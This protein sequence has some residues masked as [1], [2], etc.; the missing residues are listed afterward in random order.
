M[1]YDDDDDDDDDDDGGDFIVIF[2]D[3]KNW[4]VID[5]PRE[6]SWFVVVCVCVMITYG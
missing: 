3:N 4:N 6:E 5:G 2:L 1:N